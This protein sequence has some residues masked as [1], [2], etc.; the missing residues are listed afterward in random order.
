MK[1]IRSPEKKVMIN[2]PHECIG[3]RY[4]VGTT[5]VSSAIPVG[6]RRIANYHQTE[7][8]R[9][10]VGTLLNDSGEG[11]GSKGCCKDGELGRLHFGLYL[12]SRWLNS[13]RPGLDW[14]GDGGIS[15]YPHYQSPRLFL[16]VIFSGRKST[17]GGD[18][19]GLWNTFLA[20]T[21]RINIHIGGDSP[22][23][24]QGRKFLLVRILRA[25]FTVIR[26]ICIRTKMCIPE[27]CAFFRSGSKL[28]ILD[29]Y[30]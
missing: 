5:R 12:L 13:R 16:A 30:W 6:I 21:G 2:T 9:K 7:S 28:R 11:N 14:L 10:W 19:T 20:V 17:I 27:I 29:G 23:K 26:F 18:R 3:I 25:R 8:C 4:G 22:G 24:G 15:L 1:V